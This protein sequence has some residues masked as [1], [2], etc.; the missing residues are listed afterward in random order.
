MNIH[1]SNVKQQGQQILTWLYPFTLVDAYSHLITSSII[2]S[3]GFL[4]H[5][6][7]LPNLSRYLPLF[8]NLN[9]LLEFGILLLLSYLISQ[10][11]QPQAALITHCCTCLVI[12]LT[13]LNHDTNLYLNQPPILLVIIISL[14]SSLILSRLHCPTLIITVAIILGYSLNWLNPLSWFNNIPG[15]STN[16][17]KIQP[18]SLFF[19]T[20]IRC[21][22]SWLGLINP[23]NAKSQAIN[24]PAATANLSAALSHQSLPYPL[25]THSL[26]TSYAFLGGIGCSLGLIF[27]LLYYHRYQIVLENLIPSMFGLNAP[28]LIKLPV[29][30]NYRFLIPFIVSPL[31]S[32][33]IGYCFINWK[34]ASPAIYQ[35]FAGTPTFLWNF[36]GTN[37]NWS[38]LLATLLAIISS[39]LIYLPFVKAEV[40][41]EKIT[42]D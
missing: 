5:L 38:A 37:G 33:L 2:N 31:V 15:I 4:R 24:S 8:L 36:L 1:L 6:L 19:L 35:I 30:F 28:L 34:W 25:N 27:A 41:H 3:N 11:F 40:D 14:I 26:Y 22:G 9:N 16:V 42:V 21:L 32:M 29:L 17:Q 12:I 20:I 13:C 7:H 10:K 39:T 18:L 23:F